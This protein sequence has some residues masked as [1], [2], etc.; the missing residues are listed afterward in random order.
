[1]INYKIND[2]NK[3]LPAEG[4]TLSGDLNMSGRLI[5]N[6]A[7][8]VDNS[9]IVNYSTL[10]TKLAS[11][12][13]Y[14]V[15]DILYTARTDLGD[16]WA[17]C[18]GS[19]INPD[20]EIGTFP[21]FTFDIANKTLNKSYT[22]VSAKT[23]T[24]YT[25]KIN[26]I[27]YVGVPSAGKFEIRQYS[28]I[29]HGKYTTLGTL[30]NSN[31]SVPNRVDSKYPF[32][33]SNDGYI[34][35]I[36][37]QGIG[38]Y[39]FNIATK[40]FTLWQSITDSSSIYH[41]VYS[42][43]IG[44]KY[45]TSMDSYYG[46]RGLYQGDSFGAL[47]KSIY[48]FGQNNNYQFIEP[49]YKCHYNSNT[50]KLY[51]VIILAQDSTE[52]YNY[53]STRIINLADLS[54]TDVKITNQPA[55]LYNSY[56]S[57]ILQKCC[58]V[59]NTT[60]LWF[61]FVQAS[62]SDA[63]YRTTQCTLD[64]SNNSIDFNGSSWYTLGP[65]GELV[66]FNGYYYSIFNYSPSVTSSSY[67]PRLHKSKTWPVTD[68]STLVK[69]LTTASSDGRYYINQYNGDSWLYLSDTEIQYAQAFNHD[70]NEVSYYQ[71]GAGYSVLPTI[72]S[73]SSYVYIKVK[74]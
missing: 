62:S 34:N 10:N 16:K 11:T 19:Q 73:N 63:F 14:K 28:D 13:P 59:P 38:Y 60:K 47:T 69:Q 52:E 74:E 24:Y 58:L 5:K 12:D 45:Y 50:N 30:S 48:T 41:K 15:G 42:I 32:Y 56:S 31:I 66:Y 68:S 21:Q 8:P 37:G 54:Y 33:S 2:R 26:N 7:N 27:Y 6:V 64:M 43:K 57:W 3:Y 44:N 29:I 65:D 23:L 4:G 72:S 36:F 46:N 71:T 25:L 53:A 70:A 55:Y 40:T 49:I 22:M 35:I 51:S 67:Y 61:S 20:Y 18:N 39:R 1:M 17:L 9:D